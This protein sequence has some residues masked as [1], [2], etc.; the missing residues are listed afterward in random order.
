MREQSFLT[1]LFYHCQ[2]YSVVRRECCLLIL[3]QSQL[4]ICYILIH[5]VIRTR[6]TKCTNLEVRSGQTYKIHR[7]GHT[8]IYSVPNDM[9]YTCLMLVVLWMVVSS[10]SVDD[11]PWWRKT[12]FYQVYP[13]SFKDSNGDGTGDIR[14]MSTI[15]R[16][17]TGNI[18]AINMLRST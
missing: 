2:Y 4:C 12:N 18:L 3:L 15:N 13:R 1:L 5:P 7:H 16:E 6:L 11:I 17:Y 14:G 8:P 9:E 10:S